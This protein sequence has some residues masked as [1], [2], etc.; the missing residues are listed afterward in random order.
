LHILG[1]PGPGGA[2]GLPSGAGPGR[3]C[4]RVGPAS[5]L[6]TACARSLPTPS[7]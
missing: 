6:R 1:R 4:A 2:L 3:A 5:C 7:C